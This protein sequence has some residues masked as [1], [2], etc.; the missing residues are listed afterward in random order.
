VNDWFC[1]IAE[2]SQLP[3][4]AA[5]RLDTDGFCIVPG[6]VH[7]LRRPTPLRSW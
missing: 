2:G 7:A 4:E 6:P 5:I 3:A 1:T